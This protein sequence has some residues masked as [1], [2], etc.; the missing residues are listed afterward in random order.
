MACRRQHP[1]RRLKGRQHTI[2]IGC[3][4]H[5]TQIDEGISSHHG[6]LYTQPSEVQAIGLRISIAALTIL[7]SR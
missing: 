7:P 5:H 6:R 3:V 2:E 4:V 1:G